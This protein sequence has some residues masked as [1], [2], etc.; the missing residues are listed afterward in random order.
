MVRKRLAKGSVGNLYANSPTLVAVEKV[1]GKKRRFTLAKE[2]TCR[3][4]YR[5]AQAT[6]RPRD[7]TVR[8]I[9]GF[10]LSPEQASAVKVE[11]ARRGISLKKL[12][13]EMWSLYETNNKKSDHA[14]KSR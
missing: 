5:M 3:H 4:S 13:D 7:K 12:F 11:A 6:S 14:G 10:S 9:V 1:L 2:S 8:Q